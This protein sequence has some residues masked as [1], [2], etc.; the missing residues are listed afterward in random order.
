MG[1][2]PLVEGLRSLIQRETNMLS[3]NVRDTWVTVYNML[4]WIKDMK[5]TLGSHTRFL[6]SHR[7]RLNEQEEAIAILKNQ[8][9]GLV[10]RVSR[11]ESMLKGISETV[12]AHTEILNDIDKDLESVEEDVDCMNDTVQYTFQKVKFLDYLPEALSASMQAFRKMEPMASKNTK[13]TTGPHKNGQ[14]CTGPNCYFC[15]DE[16]NSEHYVDM[17]YDVKCEGCDHEDCSTCGPK[18]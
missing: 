11:L 3:S 15:E 13:D 14:E 8:N 5:S 2:D 18:T 6:L 9:K 12:S 1:S 17:G 10:S 7:R 4:G 16:I